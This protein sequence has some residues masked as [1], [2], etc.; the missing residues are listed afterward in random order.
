MVHPRTI[1]VVTFQYQLLE[2]LI[3]LA[4]EEV[5]QLVLQFLVDVRRFLEDLFVDLLDLQALHELHAVEV[6][7]VDK[8][9]VVEVLGG[10]DGEEAGG[11]S[12]D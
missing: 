11:E 10:F 12:G 6:L 9:E 4:L 8:D 7:E 5:Q 1:V 2:A 3:E